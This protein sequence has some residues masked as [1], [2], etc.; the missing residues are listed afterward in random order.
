[1]RTDV[2]AWAAAHDVAIAWPEDYSRDPDDFRAN[3]CIDF[4]RVV[5]REPQFVLRPADVDQLAASMVMLRDRGVPYHVRGAGHSS[6]GQPLSDGGAVIHT[7]ALSRIVEDRPDAEQIV[8]LGGTWWLP[9]VEHLAAQG[10]RPVALTG[11]GRV[12]IA[13]S[14]SAGG[15]GDTTHLRGL[16]VRSVDALTLVTP[17][18]AR[19][20]LR[21]G[22]ELFAYALAGRGQLGVIAD[23]TLRTIRRPLA[24]AARRMRWTTLR[25]FVRDAALIA[26]YRLYEYVRA[27]VFWDHTDH[28]DG[29]VGHFTDR[30][31]ASRSESILRPELVTA[32]ELHDILAELRRL[33]DGDEWTLPTPA[34]EVALP[35]PEGI[36]LWPRLR[37]RVVAGGLVPFLGRGTSVMVVPPEPELP[38]APA[39]ARCSSLLIALRP[40]APAAEARGLLPTLRAIG[41]LALAA[42][43]RI[44][45]ISTELET[46]RFLERQFGDPI[47]ARLRA[48]KAQLDPGGLCNPGLVAGAT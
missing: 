47:A 34:M 42:G 22:D 18:G 35:L 48:L 2:A 7:A 15:F 32:V 31:F 33:P 46:P 24:V 3:P 11:N 14:L 45:L 44:H 21:R 38:L 6:G 43:G 41:E 30:P 27:R 37:D 39:L 12:S 8:A 20:T 19:R 25:D 40:E 17:D 4:G 9:I 28:V 13:G 1:M 36:E 5:H 29:A 16:V 26:R 10:R 23:A